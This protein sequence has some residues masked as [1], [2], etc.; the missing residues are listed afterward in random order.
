M[1]TTPHTEESS[2]PQLSDSQQT[3]LQELVDLFE[4]SRD[5]GTV[6]SPE[7]LCSRD[8]ELLRPLLEILSRLTSV[9]LKLSKVP[10]LPIPEQI[11]EYSVIE[12]LGAGATGVVFRCRQQNPSREVAIK[13]LKPLLKADKQKRRFEREMAVMSVIREPGMA[14]V[15]QSGIVNWCGVRCFWIAMELLDGGDICEYT[16]SHG[17]D[18]HDVLAWFRT[19]CETLRAAHRLGILH[20][21]IKPSNILMS[22]DGKPHLVDFGIAR[23]P[24]STHDGR[25]TESE[26][27]SARGTAAWMAPELLLADSPTVG[28]VRSEIFGLGVVLF[29]M[30]SGQHPFGADRLSVPQISARISQRQQTS[31]ADVLPTASMD[32]VWF[33]AKLMAF[34]ADKRYQNLDE[35]LTDLTLLANGEPVRGRMIPV[36][37]RCVRWCRRHWKTAITL[38]VILSA[39]IAVAATIVMTS[40]SLEKQAK[41]LLARNQQLNSQALKLQTQTSELTESIRQQNRSISNGTLR[42]LQYTVAKSPVSVHRTLNDSQQFPEDRRGFAWKLLNYESSIDCQSLPTA[43]DSVRQMAFSSDGTQLAFSTSDGLFTI[44]R[45]DGGDNK[46]GTVNVRPAAP[47]LRRGTLS[48]W[49][50]ITSAGTLV[51]LSCDDGSIVQEFPETRGM[52]VRFT[53]SSD[54]ERV[55]GVTQDRVPF[56]LHLRANSVQAFP[57]QLTKDICGLWFSDDGTMASFLDQTGLWQQWSINELELRRS[58]TMRDLF[59]TLTRLSLA[60][61]SSEFGADGLIALAQGNGMIHVRPP[62]MT[63][64]NPSERIE[65]HGERVRQMLF[66]SPH[67]LVTVGNSV[68]LHHLLQ[69]EAPQ[70]LPAAEEKAMAVAWNADTQRMAIGG[71]D[72]SVTLVALTA[73]SIARHAG[74]P[75]AGI[76]DRSF[77]HPKSLLKLPDNQILVGHTGGWLANLN[78]KSGTTTEAFFLENSGP[79][80]SMDTH[81]SDSLV[82]IGFGGDHP[83]IKILRMNEVGRFCPPNGNPLG[84]SPTPVASLSTDADVRVVR[85][86]PDGKHLLVAFRNGEVWKLDCASWA[87]V[88]RWKCHDGGVFAMAIHGEFCITG[89]NDGFMSLMLISDGNVVLRW[90]AHEK[91]IMAVLFSPDGSRIYSASQDGTLKIWNTTGEMLHLLNAHVGRIFGL[92]LSNEGQT[93]VSGGEDRRILLWDAETGD[94]QREIAGHAD[95]VS[96]LAFTEDGRS[97]VSSALDGNVRVW[98][99]DGP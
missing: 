55:I 29:E 49:L 7:N 94:L 57:T 87:T 12:Q 53:V 77:G 92:E 66:L 88:S 51:E 2:S 89:G 63:A 17:H 5:A 9:D 52:H 95:H 62:V 71:S 27:V 73:P 34:D 40:Q 42:S 48:S 11:G 16:K 74:S 28:D 50:T 14:E 99:P 67:H 13:V 18:E 70:I 4:L 38:A 84:E 36:Q 72:G 97:L 91:R 43:A 15:Y 75:F 19:I 33:T 64:H 39:M 23:L 68:R 22:S 6:I 90:P 37:E 59:P 32:L 20:R 47:I 56:V 24:G 58:Q 69:N 86:L 3:R 81:P 80:N 85:F 10:A 78:S 46:K 25:Q 98:S 76:P 83:G 45:L 35:V 96:A 44:Y 65:L 8:P 54:G 21:D 60:N 61:F 93:L 31:L 1:S 41:L 26:H 30:L 79:V 82:A